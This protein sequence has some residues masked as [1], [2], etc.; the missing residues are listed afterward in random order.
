MQENDWLYPHD[1]RV[2]Y[3]IT[4]KNPYHL[5]TKSNDQSKLMNKLTLNEPENDDNCLFVS[6]LV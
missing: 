3:H 1:H 5:I 2:S 6:D 4:T